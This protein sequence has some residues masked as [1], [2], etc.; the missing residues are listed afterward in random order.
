MDKRT[1]IFKQ[2][3]FNVVLPAVLGLMILGIIN[4]SH[5][6]NIL[7][8]SNRQKNQIITDEIKYIHE[9][10]DM[11][12]DILED[13]LDPKMREYSETLTKVFFKNTAGIQN[14]NLSEIQEKLGMDPH[15]EDIYIINKS[16][17]IVNTTFERDRNLNLFSFGAEHKALL[18]SVFTGESFVS[19]R[20]AI[21]NQTKR[22][23][24]FTYQ[25]TSDG[26]YIIEL[27]IYSPKADTIIQSIKDRINDLSTRVKSIVS[28]DLFIGMDTPFSLNKDA[29]IDPKHLSLYRNVLATGNTY[30]FTE[31]KDKKLYHYEFIYMVRKN[32]DLYKESVIRIISDRSDDR[33]YLNKELMKFF[34][35]F[36]IIIMV[37]VILIY[38]K[39]QVITD[40]VKNLLEKVNRITDGHLNERAEIVGNNEI[41][42]LS[43]QFNRMI[44][45]LESYYNELEEKV[46]ERTAEIMA[47]KEEIEA[48]RDSIQEQRNILSDINKSLQKAYHEI[49]EQKKHIE[50][51]IHYARRIQNAILPP[52]DFVSNL[53]PD[54]F[55]LYKPKDIVSGDFYWMAHK[56]GRAIVA[57][58]DC[59]GH[60]VPGA[61]M[62]IVGNN[63]LNF[64]I[65]VKNVIRPD[66]ILNA[67]NEGVTKSLR[68][69]RLS[70]SVKDGMDIALIT[71]DYKNAKLNYAGGYNP[72]F[73]IRDNELIVLKADKF[74]IGG[75]MG[76]KLR[77]FTNNEMDLKKGDV[78]YL[79]SDGYADQF[80]GE[81]DSKFLIKRFRD[82]LLKI[83]NEPMNEQ[84]DILNQ[85]HED[86]RG[87]SV[88]IDDILVIGIRF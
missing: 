11:A 64:A 7:L 58:V 72:C 49:E 33:A 22:L 61:F 73:I 14:V 70:S 37:V 41:A 9:M 34:I 67:L 51:S 62:S 84:K 32:T 83:H 47:Q 86:W 65:N 85:I 17:V 79:F 10:Q 15:F 12:L 39:T 56:D 75:Y 30:D 4:Y 16:G 53:L 54:S 25:P 87:D 78:I 2:L 52:D 43:E 77:N 31:E 71:I 3:I 88:Q 29:T 21:E 81:D 13:G 80:G 76:E 44:E 66:D 36:G 48:Q 60:G 20:F 42:S 55:V 6:K 8:E 40:P 35:I 57:A 69:T 26:K 50:D 24:K 23:R 46:R 18:E 63:Q 59:T 82:L 27:G 74:P 5:T 38:R 68:Q 1:T 28:V 19:E 45:Q